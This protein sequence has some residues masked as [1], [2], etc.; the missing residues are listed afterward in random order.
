MDVY[1]ELVDLGRR[2][3]E[4]RGKYKVNMFQRDDFVYPPE[5]LEEL[6]RISEREKE[7]TGMDGNS[8]ITL[9]NLNLMVENIVRR[10]ASDYFSKD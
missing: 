1:T 10:V 8:V 5:D 6:E 2:R 4:I 7:L 3:Q 9:P